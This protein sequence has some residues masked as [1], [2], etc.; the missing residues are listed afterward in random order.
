MAIVHVLGSV[1]DERCFSF[2][3]FLKSKLRTNLDPHLPLGVG[4]YNQKFFTLETFPYNATFDAWVGPAER[5][6]ILA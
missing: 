6:V 1:E 2:L 5:Y 3:A 4:M